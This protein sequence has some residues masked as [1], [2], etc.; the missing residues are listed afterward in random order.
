METYRRGEEKRDSRPGTIVLGT[1]RIITKADIDVA[2]VT[3]ILD[4]M[5]VVVVSK[6]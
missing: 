2:K 4:A 1:H 5:L 3:M 6:E